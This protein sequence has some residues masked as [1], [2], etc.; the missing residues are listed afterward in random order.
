MGRVVRFR[1]S[2]GRQSHWR[3]G[4]Q[5]KGGCLDRSDMRV[6]V[7]GL[8]LGGL[9]SAA[10]IGWPEVQADAPSAV[11]FL[12]EP[13]AFEC[14]SPEIVDGDTIRCGSQRVRLEGI[15]AP[16]MP[17]HCRPGRECVAGD[18]YASSAS[19]SK[20]VASGKV[21]CKQTDTDRYGRVVARCSA[22]TVDLSCRQI[23]N[24][25]AVSRYAAI[26]C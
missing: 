25:M 6:V 10:I 26:D 8:A 20:L 11:Q 15:D 5:P 24:G 19:L 13:G 21:L 16:E 22:G 7:M 14:R 17:G 1:G 23:E 18:P 2:A 3:K 12:S 4:K 9:I